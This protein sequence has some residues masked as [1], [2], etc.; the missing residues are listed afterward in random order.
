MHHSH[1]QK[2]CPGVSFPH[3][4]IALLCRFFF[5]FRLD[6]Y[7]NQDRRKFYKILRQWTLM[8]SQMIHNHHAPKTLFRSVNSFYPV[9]LYVF[10]E[11]VLILKPSRNALA[12][13][14]SCFFQLDRNIYKF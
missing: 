8:I 7:K 5:N 1:I 14:K 2:S 4:F 13:W 11:G 9:N 10:L 12:L 3:S 6:G